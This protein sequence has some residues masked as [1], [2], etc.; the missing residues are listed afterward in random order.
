MAYTKAGDAFTEMVLETFRL[1]GRLLAAGDRL[2]KPLGL[3][4]S[5]WQVL[6]TIESQPLSVSQIAKRIGLTRQ[7]VQRMAD[8]LDQEGF[9]SYAPN[10]EHE[11]AKLVRLTAK[12][13][14]VM[15]QLSE[16]QTVWA[17]RVS[18]AATAADIRTTLQTMS[19]LAAQL[20][21]DQTTR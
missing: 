15:R 16:I 7:N 5:R 21:R 18:A 14:R 3:T 13:T 10:P 2:T 17:N 19:K 8:I 6:G 4:S 11:R 1:N 9:V 20:E 12:A